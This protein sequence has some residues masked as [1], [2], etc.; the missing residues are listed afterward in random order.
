MKGKMIILIGLLWSVI[1]AQGQILNTVKWSYAAKKT[2]SK[3]AVLYLKATVQPG[4]HVFSVNQKPGGPLTTTFTFSKNAEYTLVGNV[5]EPNPILKFDKTFG[6]EIMYFENEVIFQ[7]KV[8]LK[9]SKGVVKGKV[10]FMACNDTQCLPPEELKFS[11]P[12]K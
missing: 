10:E 3:E 2:S 12:V 1:S 9:S 5:T 6:I 11:I 4:W 7:Q 8:K